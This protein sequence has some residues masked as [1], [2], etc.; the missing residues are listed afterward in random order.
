[1]ARYHGKGGRAYVSTTGTG[2]AVSIV[3]LESWELNMPTDLEEVTATSDENKT[4]VQ[5]YGDLKGKLNFLWS[6]A[7]DTLFTAAAS[8]DGCKIYLYPSKD[9]ITKY[10]YGPAWLNLDT[11]GG[12]VKAAVKGAAGFAANGAW[13]RK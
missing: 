2:N 8:T 13:G 3:N 7:E 1:M 12:G 11:L 10:W 6:D 9:A 4:Y 5:G